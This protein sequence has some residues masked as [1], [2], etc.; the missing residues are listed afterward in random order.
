MGVVVATTPPVAFVERRPLRIPDTVRFV[1][2][3]VL[4]KP[5]PLAVM[6]V[7]DAPPFIEKSPEVMVED[8][9]ERKPANV[10]R[11]ETFVVPTRERLPA[12]SN[13]LVALPPK[14]A[15][16]KTDNRVVEAAA[17]NC[18]KALHVFA[19]VVENGEPGPSVDTPQDLTQVIKAFN[20][21]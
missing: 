20:R 7:V 5:V 16:S 14:Y 9:V 4:K 10:E 21:K 8:A 12:E 11:P 3:A 19:V 15:L 13:V 18:C 6:F 17:A 2:D 1:V